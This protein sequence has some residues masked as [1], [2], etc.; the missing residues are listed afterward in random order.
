VYDEISGTFLNSAFV[1][2]GTYAIST[3]WFP[4]A[5]TNASRNHQASKDG[6]G[7]R[8]FTRGSRAHRLS[9]LSSGALEV[10]IQPVTRHPRHHNA[11]SLLMPTSR[12]TAHTSAQQSAGQD[13]S[14]WRTFGDRCDLW[15]AT[16]TQGYF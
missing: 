12:A 3:V 2:I 13:N 15:G 1:F 16:G 10:L 6:P 7:S 14:G 11:D 8:D 9:R 4:S 5:L